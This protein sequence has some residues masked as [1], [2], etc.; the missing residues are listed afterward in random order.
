MIEEENFPDRFF[1][2]VLQQLWKKNSFQRKILVTT[3]F[4]T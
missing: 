1:D 3:G 4:Y 2:T